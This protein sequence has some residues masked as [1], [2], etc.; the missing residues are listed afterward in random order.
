MKRV[1]KIA[2]SVGIVAALEF[3]LAP[4]LWT[5][6]VPCFPSSS[7]YGYSSLSFRFF[8][9]GETYRG[10]QFLWMTHGPDY[11]CY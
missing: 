9:L 3:F 4:V 10:G 11:N 8:N 2:I 7:G 1:A 5:V 6:I